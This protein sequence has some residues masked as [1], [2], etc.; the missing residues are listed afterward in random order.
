M[1]DEICREGYDA[2]LGTFV[3][4]Y[5]AES[6]DASL[7]LLPLVGFLPVGDDRISRTIDAIERELNVDGLVHRR[8]P[9]HQPQQGAFLACSCW[10]AECRL[11]QGRR[12]A[13][14]KTFERVLAVAND[15]GLLAEEYDIGAKRLAGNFP[16]ALS[17]VALVRTAL[18][19]SAATTE[20]GQGG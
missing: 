8:R 16:Q 3:E 5:G 19:F 7:L 6:L 17:H 10:L 2:G 11:L 15:L 4:Y 13:A 12:E 18:R 14:R 9:P 1:H 20:R